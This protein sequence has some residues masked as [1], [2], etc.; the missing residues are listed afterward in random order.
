MRAVLAVPGDEGNRLYMLVYCRTRSLS[1]DS[2]GVQL[3]RHVNRVYW[4]VD[5]YG[6]PLDMQDCEYVIFNRHFLIR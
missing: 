3:F 2:C 5:D 1:A 6:G 4:D